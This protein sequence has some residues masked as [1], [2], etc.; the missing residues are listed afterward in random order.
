[1]KNQ[2]NALLLTAALSGLIGG[3]SS[4]LTRPTT[5]ANANNPTVKAAKAGLRYTSRQAT[6]A[7]L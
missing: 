4:R 1:M 2:F 6:Q 7:L 5:S 3:T